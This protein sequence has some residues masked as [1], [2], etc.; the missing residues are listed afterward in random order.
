M[1]REEDLSKNILIKGEPT[2]HLKVALFDMDG[3][4]F[5]SMP[6]HAKAWKA[7]F[8][9]MGIKTDEREFF[10]IEGANP[11]LAVNT[12]LEREWGRPAT[13]E[14]IE[15]VYVR[16]VDFFKAHNTAEPMY[17]ADLFLHKVKE[18]GLTAVVVTGSAQFSMIDRIERTYPNIFDMDKI[19]TGRMVQHGKPYPDPYL[20]GLEHCSCLPNEAIVI[21]NAPFGVRAGKG[22]GIRV[23][24]VN[25]GPLPSKALIDEGADFLFDSMEELADKWE[26]LYEYITKGIL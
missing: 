14:E 2:P 15:E 11:T 10:L 9:S 4:L 19:V 7:S 21:E 23:I 16:K 18:K 1:N 24:A 3:V 20:M 13:K 5:D 8:A 26:L 17:K 12:I 6:S 25:T 22:A